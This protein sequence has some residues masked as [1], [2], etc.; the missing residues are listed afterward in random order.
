MHDPRIDALANVLLDHSCE[1]KSGETIL[2]E[3]IDLPEP[4]LICA[5]VEGAA[6]RGATPLVE[7]KNQRV[8]RSVLSTAT[9]T[10]M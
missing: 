2:I 10:A 9:E 1:L 6:Q 4:D 3:A 8:Q 7:I 5:L